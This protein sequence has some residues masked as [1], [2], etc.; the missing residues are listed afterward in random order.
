MVEGCIEMRLMDAHLLPVSLDVV[1][2]FL[3]S[4]DVGRRGN[5]GSVRG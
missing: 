2:D 5:V 1:S 3:G 4:I